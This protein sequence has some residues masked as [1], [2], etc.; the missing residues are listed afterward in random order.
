MHLDTG[1]VELVLERGLAELGQGFGDVG[2]GLG[3]HRLDRPEQLD[4]EAR[5][6]RSSVDERGPRHGGQVAREHRR[7]A[8]QVGLESGGP[9]HGFGHQS[10]EGPLAQLADQQP[11]HE[12]LLVPGRACEQLAQQA[13]LC[14]GRTLAGGVGETLE[15]GV[16]LDDLER[17]CL[18]G[19]LGLR[20]LEGGIADADPSLP[21]GARE[22]GDRGFDFLIELAVERAAI[23]DAGERIVMRQEAGAEIGSCAFATVP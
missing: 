9:R 7:A 22:K 8:H 4:P 19:A 12:F 15:R 13:A 10:L 20:G 11:E 2:R 17:G 1:P 23:G 14:L 5:E 3:E 18:G 6:P 21:G 16:H